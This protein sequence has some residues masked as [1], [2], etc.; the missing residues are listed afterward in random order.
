M[1]KTN[2]ASLPCFSTFFSF[3]KYIYVENIERYMSEKMY[4]AKIQSALKIAM[5]NKL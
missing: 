2:T 4:L 3:I 1:A 5:Q